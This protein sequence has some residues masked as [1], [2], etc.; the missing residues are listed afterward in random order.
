MTFYIHK[1]LTNCETEFKELEN[2]SVNDLYEWLKKN[3]EEYNS[4]NT[5]LKVPLPNLLGN[6]KI[7]FNIVTN[8]QK[9]KS[10]FQTNSKTEKPVLNTKR[11]LRKRCRFFPNGSQDFNSIISNFLSVNFDNSLIDEYKSK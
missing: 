8:N 3:T 7:N 11:Y 10:P 5:S 1:G 2:I 4:T 6:Q 9:S